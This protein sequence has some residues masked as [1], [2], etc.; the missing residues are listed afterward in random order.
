MDFKVEHLGCS[1]IL[2]DYT[3]CRRR[4][5]R[6]AYMTSTIHPLCLKVCFSIQAQGATA[7]WFR[8]P[9]FLRETQ[10]GVNGMS[11]RLYGCCGP[12]AC[13]WYSP[14]PSSTTHSKFLSS[15]STIS[16]GDHDLSGGVIQT[17][18]SEPS[19]NLIFTSFSI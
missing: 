8:G 2:S 7:P 3:P 15:Q 12:W 19:E 6:S 16:A 10:K 11:Y 14:S 4:Y 18:I 13:N 17:I 1:V 9:F 5:F